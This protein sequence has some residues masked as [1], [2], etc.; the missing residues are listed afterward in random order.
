MTHWILSLIL[1]LAPRSMPRLLVLAALGPV[2]AWLEAPLLGSHWMLVALVDIAILAAALGARRD[3]A[4]TAC[5]WLPEVMAEVAQAALAR[6]IE[7]AYVRRFV[8][9]HSLPGSD[10]A[11]ADWPWPLVLRAFGA[12][13]ARLHDEPLARVGGKTAQ[14]PLDLLRALLAQG[15]GGLP[16]S[17]AMRWLWPEADAAAQRKSFDVALLRLGPPAYAPPMGARGKGGLWQA[18]FVSQVVAFKKKED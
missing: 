14:R 16:V 7:P 18:G 3:F 6:E 12:F 11:Q 10:P 15:A 2:S 9:R 13:E 5:W 4:V 1:L 17:T 8:R